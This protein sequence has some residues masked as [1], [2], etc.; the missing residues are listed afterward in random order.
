MGLSRYEYQSVV[1]TSRES[2]G[3]W[4]SSLV[5]FGVG[6]VPDR[7]C[8]SQSYRPRLAGAI[9][10]RALRRARSRSLRP[11]PRAPSCVPRR[12]P[13]PTDVLFPRCCAPCDKWIGCP[14][15][16]CFLSVVL[17]AGFLFFQGARR[18]VLPRRDVF[19]LMQ[20]AV[21]GFCRNGWICVL[22]FVADWFIGLGVN[23]VCDDFVGCCKRR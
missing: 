3:C 20:V 14:I 5:R 4:H 1:C 8:H 16:F 7:T 23:C 15:I 9:G 21:G 17:R 13:P 12:Q 11:A 22:M 19:V 2:W 6:S 10:S 18:W